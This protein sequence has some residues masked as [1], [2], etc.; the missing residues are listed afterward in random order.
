MNL[1]KEE[2]ALHDKMAE[3]LPELIEE[4]LK[5]PDITSISVSIKMVNNKLA[6]KLSY[7]FGVRKKLPIEQVETPIPTSIY[8]FPTDVIEFEIPRNKEE[9]FSVEVGDSRTEKTDPLIGGISISAD[10]E[11]ETGGVKMKTRGTLGVMVNKTGDDRPY[12]VTCAHVLVGTNTVLNS[13]V[14]Q[15][16]KWETALDYCHNCAELKAYFYQNVTFVRDS[17]PIEAWL[18]CAI[19]RKEWFRSVTIGKVY[20]VLKLI[21]G[22]VPE[23]NPS[24]I[25][26]EVCK[27]GIKTDITKGTIQSIT[28]NAKLE[29]FDGTEVIARN[30]I[31]VIGSSGDF[32]QPGDSGSA[33][34]LTENS[35]MIGLLAAGSNTMSAVTASDAILSKWPDLKF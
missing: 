7:M 16:A 8:G 24:L 11:I 34:F 35:L 3:K 12:M 31:Q 21:L 2:L 26:K 32:S 27:S 17:K 30:L 25:G 29:N 15:Q 28:L 1:S 14:C 23:I 4:Y 19:A 9:A 33:V 13:E 6:D 22:F 20:G 5:R 18:D 10:G